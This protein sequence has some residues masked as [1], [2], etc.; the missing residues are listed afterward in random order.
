[1]TL[2]LMLALSLLP[3]LSLGAQTK[4]APA[5]AKEKELF[6]LALPATPLLV[7][8][9]FFQ[10]NLAKAAAFQP[11]QLSAQRPAA[12]TKEPAYKGKP[13]Y[14][15]VKLGNLPKSE[16]LIAVDDE[17]KA[18]HVDG[19]QNGDLTDDSPVAWSWQSTGKKEEGKARTFA[20]HWSVEAGFDLGGGKTRRSP[21]MLDT[22]HEEGSDKL[23]YRVFNVRSGRVDLK[24]RT[25]SAMVQSG[26]PT[27]VVLSDREAAAAQKQGTGVV[28]IDLN[29]DGTFA[30]MGMRKSFGM[31]TAVEVQ[32][33]WM[34]FESNADGSLVVA[35]SAVAPP[36]AAFK[37]LPPKKVG[38]RIADFE[39]LMPDGG[40]VKLSDHKGK[41]VVLDFWATW[42]GPCLAAMPKVEAH[43]KALKHNPNLAVLGVCVGDEKAA[44]DKWI[45]EKGPNYSF[46]IGFD[47]AGRQKLGKDLMYLNGVNMIPTTMV[48]DPQGVVLMRF[49]GLTADNEKALIKLLEEKGIKEK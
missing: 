38:D 27:G 30:P 7:Q 48:L 36:E 15:S 26:S 10:R 47:P 18:V 8:G 45:K 24:G 3:G 20:G 11:V 37:P 32:G 17:A 28:Y 23:G 33:E 39:M 4:S 22:M 21:L 49:A 35:R 14:G 43:W 16:Y 44:F 6:R 42:C 19:N 46:P 25:Y 31:G 13:R 2:R 29:G 12:V 1:M 9:D 34:T 40:K 41:Y 5:P